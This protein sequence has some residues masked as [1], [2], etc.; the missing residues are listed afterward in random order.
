MKTID[1]LG[2]KYTIQELNPKKDKSL[3]DCNGYVDKSTKKIV[4]TTEPENSELGNWEWYRKKILRHEIIHA[5]FNESGLQENWENKSFG[6][7]ETIVDWIA[8]QF[9]K[10]EIAFR[11]AGA[12]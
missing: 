5:F 1:V 10:L 3:Q 11:D 8:I 7:S 12:L 2:T 9:P 4:I 6:Q